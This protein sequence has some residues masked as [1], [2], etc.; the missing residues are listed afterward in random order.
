M[1]FGD[2][3]HLLKNKNNF[4]TDYFATE[5]LYVYIKAHVIILVSIFFSLFF[6]F[7]LAATLAGES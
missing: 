2:F 5:F 3:D 1:T 4:A 7:S 6:F